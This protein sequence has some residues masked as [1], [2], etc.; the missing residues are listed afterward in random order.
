M[1]N[2]YIL[3]C[4]N[5][6]IKS[7]KHFQNCIIHDL[8]DGKGLAHHRNVVMKEAFDRGEKDLWML[9]D[10]I[11]KVYKKGP[12]VTSKKTGKQYYSKEETVLDLNNIIFP[13]N[14][15]V[16]GIS[17]GIFPF[18]SKSGFTDIVTCAAQVIYINLEL[19]NGWEMPETPVGEIADDGE[20]AAYAFF[21]GWG[22]KKSNDYS[23]TCD[24]SI[25]T[26]SG[27]RIE[28][29]YSIMNTYKNYITQLPKLGRT[30]FRLEK[31]WKE[32]L[33]Q[34]PWQDPNGKNSKVYYRNELDKRG[35]WI[36]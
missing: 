5:R 29:W 7:D 9:D 23:Y 22:V 28:L 3:T 25:T 13:P 30:D 8:T 24:N 31:A 14:T 34:G 18:S 33:K 17:K 11:E 2:T 21:K 35:L 27:K 10:D 20:I 6:P 1:A 36:D 19:L 15:A 32:M 12:L 4:N 26:F 16:G